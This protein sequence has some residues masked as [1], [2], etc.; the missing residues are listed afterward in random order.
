[1]RAIV[2]ACLL[3][4]HLFY[5]PRAVFSDKPEFLIGE[6]YNLTK[7]PRSV[8]SLETAHVVGMFSLICE[9]VI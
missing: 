7:A 6:Y 4:R 8:A 1:L 2:V 3:Y 5:V 9:E